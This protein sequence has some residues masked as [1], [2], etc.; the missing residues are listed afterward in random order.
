MGLEC[1]RKRTAA[2]LGKK[3]APLK[4]HGKTCIQLLFLKIY[5]LYIYL[6]LL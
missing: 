3:Q 2:D 6:K 5:C 1:N 4:Q